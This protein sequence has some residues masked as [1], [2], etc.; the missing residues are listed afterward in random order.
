MSHSLSVVVVF[1]GLVFVGL[2]LVCLWH[3]NELN[4]RLRGRSEFSMFAVTRL[5]KPVLH[6][7]CLMLLSSPSFDEENVHA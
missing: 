3:N 4:S 2:G 7:L 5:S 6:A 1:V